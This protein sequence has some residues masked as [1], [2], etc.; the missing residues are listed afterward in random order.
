MTALAVK[1]PSEEPIRDGWRETASAPPGYITTS[2]AARRARCSE[3]YTGS[4]NRETLR[5]WVNATAENSGESATP[6][7]LA[8]D[9][10]TGRL[11]RWIHPSIHPAFNEPPNAER[12][13][14]EFKGLPLHKQAAGLARLRALEALKRFCNGDGRRLGLCEARTRFFEAHREAF[15]YRV[16]ARVRTLN[17]NPSNLSRW[18]KRYRAGGLDALCRDDRGKHGRENVPAEL[19]TE[20]WSWRC[21]PGN[22][23]HSIEA[24]HRIM[25]LRAEQTGQTWFA[26][27]N[28]TRAYDRRHRD[29]KLLALHQ[30]GERFYRAK[31]APYIEVDPDSFE[32]GEAIECD[33]FTVNV[34]SILR[35]AVIRGV[36]SGTIDWHGRAVSA[37][38]TA[39]GSQDSV[40]LSIR[41]HWKRFGVSSHAFIDNGKGY[42]SYTWRGDRPRRHR[43]SRGADFE[44]RAGGLFAAVGC[45]PHWVT[46]YSPNSKGRIERFGRTLDERLRFL[47]SYC[48]NTPDN[49]PDAHARLIA[50]AIPF[51][52]LAAIIEREIELYNDTPHGGDG[53]NMMTPLQVMQLAPRKR[54]LDERYVDD[55]LSI[56][57]RPVKVGR[58]GVTITY[59]GKRLSFGAF[60]RAVIALQGQTVRASYDPEDLS[61]VCVYSLDWR[62]LCKTTLNQR[63]NKKLPGEVLREQIRF[64][65]RQRRVLREAV[66]VGTE[67]IRSEVDLAYAAMARDAER[68]R[69]PDPD[70]P[71]GGP[72]LAPVQS[73]LELPPKRLRKAVG[74]EHL[75]EAEENADARLREFL[76]RGTE[77]PRK[78]APSGF[79]ALAAWAARQRK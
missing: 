55:L 3:H 36:L 56:H 6:P 62:F 74:A 70:P 53:M 57:H 76:S 18:E 33:D 26:S 15:T 32:P 64:R 25:M 45:E 10:Q 22:K 77:A 39:N 24:I 40:L 11:R 44:D 78:S 35:G 2:E 29:E 43:Y 46:P 13:S 67:Y 48:G 69:L 14:K 73:P 9:P 34:W 27:P 47:P 4:R 37:V 63:V 72:V 12:V 1:L 52:E 28:T 65:N 50:K 49:R 16:G 8:P 58:Q 68:R 61:R 42:S 66:K 23:R 41:K 20:Y 59:A 71:G 7:V 75:G 30:R 17:P 19:L 21:K 38:L 54:V 31:H 79:G 5:T 51:E 60:D